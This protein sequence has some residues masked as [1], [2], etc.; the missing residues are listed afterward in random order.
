[1]TTALQS[2][3]LRILGTAIFLILVYLQNHSR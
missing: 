1:M 2:G 3:D